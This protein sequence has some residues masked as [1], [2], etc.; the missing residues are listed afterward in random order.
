MLKLTYDS[1][2][3]GIVDAAESVPWAGI[4]GVPSTFPPDSH[5]HPASDIISGTIA[6]ARLGSG[7]ANSTTFLR[8]DST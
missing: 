7:T 4:T 5:T 6:T 2:D 1:N 3:D 8:G